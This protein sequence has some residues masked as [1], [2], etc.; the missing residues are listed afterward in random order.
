MISITDKAIFI[1]LV[2][3]LA[4]YALQWGWAVLWL[5]KVVIPPQFRLI[6]WV[7]RQLKIIQLP[8]QFYSNPITPKQNRLL[9]IFALMVG[10]V[11]YAIGIEFLSEML[12]ALYH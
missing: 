5:D 10:T 7:I 8:E 9:G 11:L 3:I 2:L 4:L 12:L 1:T 6:L